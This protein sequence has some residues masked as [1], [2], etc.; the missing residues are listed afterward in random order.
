MR[1]FI[2]AVAAATALIAAQAPA[3]VGADEAQIRAIVGVTLPERINAADAK[4]V[5]ALWSETGT[6]SG[7]VLGARIRDGRADIEQ[8]WAAGFSQPSRDRLRK[9]SVAV[10]SV[11]FLRPDVAAVDA[12]NTYHGGQTADGSLKQDTGELLF[13]V[14]T[15]ENGAWMIASSR[16]VPLISSSPR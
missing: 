1:L 4:G 6:H 15:R 3:P 12:H 7:L 5:A 11:R 16:V 10:T 13:S 8:M 9:L 14:L 2:L